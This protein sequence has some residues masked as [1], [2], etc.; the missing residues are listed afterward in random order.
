MF[1]AFWSGI[2]PWSYQWCIPP[3]KVRFFGWGNWGQKSEPGPEGI[4]QYGTSQVPNFLHV[5]THCYFFFL[6]WGVMIAPRNKFHTEME[7]KVNQLVK[8]YLFQLYQLHCHLPPGAGQLVALHPHCAGPDGE[9][10]GCCRYGLIFQGLFNHLLTLFQ[11]LRRMVKR[12]SPTLPGSFLHYLTSLALIDIFLILFFL[13]DNIII[14]HHDQN[15]EEWYY[16]IVPYLTHPGKQISITM[17]VM[18]VVV[19]AVERYIAVTFPL[20]SSNRLFYYILFIVV[21]SV[22]VNWAK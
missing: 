12:K 14:N 2:F 15:K 4:T 5:F 8:T 21:F 10:C 19:L 1:D 11:V 22:T 3:C 13:L 20:R 6:G 9:Q 16:K 7:N 17:A 18:W